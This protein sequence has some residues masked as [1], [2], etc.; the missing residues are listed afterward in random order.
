M[1]VGA[2]GGVVLVVRGAAADVGGAGGA[3]ADSRSIHLGGGFVLDRSAN[4]GWYE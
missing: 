2:W 1:E 4:G 3:G